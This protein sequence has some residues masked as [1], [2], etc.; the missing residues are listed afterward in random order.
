MAAGDVK[1][2]FRFRKETVKSKTNTAVT[3]G[4]ILIYDTDGHAPG[5]QALARA[6]TS[7]RFKKCVATESVAAVTATQ[8]DLPVLVEGII[9]IR[10]VSGA[11]EKMQI[12]GL[13]T[14]A[15]RVGAW[16]PPVLGVAAWCA[17]T[18]QLELEKL[19]YA[20]G[21]VLNAAASGDDAVTTILGS[22]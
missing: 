3:K 6:S 10:K 13:T 22:I 8:T 18:V 14:T 12:V 15:G 11:L 2:T 21:E 16:T 9:D 4:D 20:V 19:G 5:T 17:T 1:K 7:K